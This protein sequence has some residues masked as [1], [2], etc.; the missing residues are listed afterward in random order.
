MDASIINFKICMLTTTQYLAE[1]DKTKEKDL[2]NNLKDCFE[3]LDIL[4][5]SFS[6][7]ENNCHLL[8]EYENL[9][10]QNMIKSNTDEFMDA[11]QL[12]T[13][14]SLNNRFKKIIT[15]FKETVS[16][17]EQYILSKYD[18]RKF[19]MENSV[20]NMDFY[21]FMNDKKKNGPTKLFVKI[22]NS[23]LEDLIISLNGQNT[24]SNKLNEIKCYV[25][26]Q[27][28]YTFLNKEVDLNFNF[29]AEIEKLQEDYL[30]Y[31]GLEHFEKNK[32]YR[33]I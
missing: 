13:M 8:N 14:G 21:T 22:E 2:Y 29:D 15:S 16:I 33:K 19:L 10:I 28:L 18:V 26:A 24:L 12:E 31:T 11:R 32:I 3:I 20:G 25:K 5:Y 23:I 4:E 7:Y 6:M 30:K 17:I 9:N 27:Y 1:I